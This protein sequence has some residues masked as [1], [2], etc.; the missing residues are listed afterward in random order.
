MSFIVG[1]YLQVG[2]QE[3]FLLTRSGDALAQ[4]PEEWWNPWR[5]GDVALRAMVSGSDGMGW[6]W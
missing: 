4:L 3:T 5:C 1:S 6:S 2:Y